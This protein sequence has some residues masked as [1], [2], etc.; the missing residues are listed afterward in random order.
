MELHDERGRT[1]L[2]RQLADGGSDCRALAEAMSLMVYRFFAELGWTAGRP[3]PPPA[4]LEVRAASPVAP[5]AVLRLAL[6]AGAGLWTRRPGTGT[7]LLGVRVEWRA[8]EVELDLLGPGAPMRERRPDGEA[9]VSA[10]AMALSVGLG[11]ER[12]RLR[13]SGGPLSIVGREWGRTRG[14]PVVRENTVTTAALGLAAGASWRLGGAWRL[15]VE[16]WGAHAVLANR[17]VVTGWGAVLAPPP[18]QGAALARMAYVF[19]L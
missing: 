11:W 19:S 14:I 12:G 5:P 18:F 2:R 4:P 15:G 1:R 8:V 10:W 6:E 13:L 3:L 17:F 7:G 9:E 16:V